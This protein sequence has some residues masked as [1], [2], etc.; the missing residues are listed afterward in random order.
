M[1][2]T[3]PRYC[4]VKAFEKRPVY[5]VLQSKGISLNLYHTFDGNKMRGFLIKKHGRKLRGF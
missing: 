1:A 2:S 3:V 5:S 4:H